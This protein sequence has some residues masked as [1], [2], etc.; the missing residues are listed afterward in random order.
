[1][2]SA[3]ALERGNGCS[4]KKTTEHQYWVLLYCGILQELYCWRLLLSLTLLEVI[5][6]D[7]DTFCGL[8]LSLTLAGGYCWSLSL[9]ALTLAGGYCWP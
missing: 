9:P 8:L 5:I 3:E 2:F 4:G 7:P 1:M 6:A